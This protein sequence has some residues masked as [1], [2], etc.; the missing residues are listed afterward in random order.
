MNN[1]IGILTLPLHRN[2]G[3]VLQNYVLTQITKDFGYEP[4]TISVLSERRKR[5][6]FIQFTL[7]NI[8]IKTY[9]VMEEIQPDDFGTYLVG[10]DQIW[11]TEWIKPRLV[12]LDFT[13]EWDVKRI[14][15]GVSTGKEGLLCTSDDIENVFKPCAKRFIGGIT[16][17]ENSLRDDINRIMGEPIA[18]TVCDPTM[19]K[20]VD[21]YNKM[22]KDVS[23]LSPKIGQYML[24]SH[25]SQLPIVYNHLK[26]DEGRVFKPYDIPTFL[27]MYRDCNMI[28]TDSFHGCLFSLIYNKPFICFWNAG[29]G[30]ARFETLIENYGIG[31][32]MIVDPDK[33][34]YSLLSRTPNV[35]YKPLVEKSFKFL[36]K[37]LKK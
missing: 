20:G 24:D 32:R 37:T 6:Q 28:L 18:Q 36:E 21:F 26:T 7:D 34:D 4:E 35:N 1:K 3:G 17:R 22:A 29:R 23:R 30:N 13:K 8:K 11:R 19:L 25:K 14:A 9:N 15:Y 33:M 10:S 12:F 5:D 16:T 31:N 2:L 27:A